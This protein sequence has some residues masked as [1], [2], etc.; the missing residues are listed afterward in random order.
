MGGPARWLAHRIGCRVTGLD[1][2]LSRAEAARRLTA[3]VGLADRVDFVH[4]D[5]RPGCRC[6]TTRSTSR[7]AR[8][9]GCIEASTAA[10]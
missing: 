10:R 2:T 7:S 4:G 9:R 1:F 5:A 6:P 8:K 3:R